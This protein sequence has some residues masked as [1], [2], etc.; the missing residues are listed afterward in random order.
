MVWWLGCNDNECHAMQYL[1]AWCDL[2]VQIAR[3]EGILGYFQGIR[4]KIVQSVLAAAILFMCKE[5]ITEATRDLLLATRTNN[6]A[7]R[8]DTA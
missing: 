8:R 1:Q 4:T 7:A 6:A 3:R 2:P 5:K